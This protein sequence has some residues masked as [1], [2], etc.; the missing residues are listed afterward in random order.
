MALTQSR[1]DYSHIVGN[2][3]RG[4]GCFCSSDAIEARHQGRA[5]S[6]ISAAENQIEIRTTLDDGKAFICIHDSGVSNAS[7]DM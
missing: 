7:K 1:V 3:R 6:D 2:T 5:F 4:G